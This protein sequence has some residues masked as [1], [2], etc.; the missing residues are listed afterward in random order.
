MPRVRIFQVD[1]FSKK[2]SRLKERP[3]GYPTDET[4]ERKIRVQSTTES[5]PCGATVQAYSQPLRV[6]VR[7]PVAGLTLAVDY[8]LRATSLSEPVIGTLRLHVSD[9]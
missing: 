4:V 5:L 2:P 6:W 8:A 1:A 9:S 7:E 3:A